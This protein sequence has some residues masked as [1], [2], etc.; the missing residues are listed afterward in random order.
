[1]KPPSAS[2]SCAG[3]TVK[4]R[5]LHPPRRLPR[6]WIP[7]C[8]TVAVGRPMRPLL[9]A[10]INGSP[11]R[12]DAERLSP[13]QCDRLRFRKARRIPS[14]QR[15]SITLASGGCFCSSAFLQENGEKARRFSARSMARSAGS[16][17]PKSCLSKK[18]YRR[19]R[20]LCASP[21]RRTL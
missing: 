12:V 10:R 8:S 21:V 6:C 19:S 4:V 17:A 3:S 16:A 7:R 9:M 11:L 15:G 2:V 20:S 14:A 18:S 5:A 1:L 13:S